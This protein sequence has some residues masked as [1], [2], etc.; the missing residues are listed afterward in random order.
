M[1]KSMWGGRFTKTTDAMMEEFNSSISFDKR[2]YREDIAGS[3]AHAA[4]LARC[5]ILTDAEAASIR[6]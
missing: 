5:G 3:M 6:Q 4:M 2:M 1:S